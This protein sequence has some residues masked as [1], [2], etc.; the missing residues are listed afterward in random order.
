MERPVTKI[1]LLL[2]DAGYKAEMFKLFQLLGKGDKK[3]LWVA[4]QI[5]VCGSMSKEVLKKSAVDAGAGVKDLSETVP[6]KVDGE[7][8]W[9][10]SSTLKGTYTDEM[11]VGMIYRTIKY[12]ELQEEGTKG[13]GRFKHKT[14]PKWDVVVEPNKSGFH[15]SK[16]YAR[17]EA[18]PMLSGG[19]S[20]EDVKDEMAG[21][22][23]DIVYI[24]D[25]GD[26]DSDDDNDE[27]DSDDEDDKEND[28][29]DSSEV[30]EGDND[31]DSSDQR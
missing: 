13:Y 25:S 1:R 28:N 22:F 2:Q 5:I 23:D 15:I 31:E 18:A 20:T 21:P 30:D 16:S 4:T 12:T 6:I 19:N 10:K 14:V 8:K 26:S 29:E 9:V 3:K 11:I 27:E 24:L 17:G 7:L